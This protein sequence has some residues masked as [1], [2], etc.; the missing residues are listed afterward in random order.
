MLLRGMHDHGS[1][2]IYIVV[3]D[4]RKKEMDDLTKYFKL[5]VQQT[6][7]RNCKYKMEQQIQSER[8]LSC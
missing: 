4:L 6:F 8:E 7:G 3:T 5:V 1:D 2:D